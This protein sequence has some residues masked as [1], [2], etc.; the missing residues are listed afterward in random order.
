MAF[1]LLAQRRPE[2]ALPSNNRVPKVLGAGAGALARHREIA[3]LV[4]WTS[5]I[6]LALA[7]AS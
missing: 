3:A 2:S 4:M 7:L 5:A 6:F 1:P